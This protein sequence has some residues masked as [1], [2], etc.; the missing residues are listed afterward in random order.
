MYAF[1]VRERRKRAQEALRV[2]P[3][4]GGMRGGLLPSRRFPMAVPTIAASTPVREIVAA[5]FSQTSG[6]NFE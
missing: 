6:P 1:R 4:A 3:L 2:E 5:R